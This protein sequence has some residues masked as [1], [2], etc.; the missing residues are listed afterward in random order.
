MD[1]LG[2]ISWLVCEVLRVLI[3]PGMEAQVCEWEEQTSPSP[4]V[5]L[6]PHQ[7]GLLPKHDP[8][9][10]FPNVHWDTISTPPTTYALGQGQGGFLINLPLLLGNKLGLGCEGREEG[11][12]FHRTKTQSATPGEPGAVGTGKAPRLHPHHAQLPVPQL[13]WHPWPE[14]EQRL[15]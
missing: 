6:P 10:T 15:L 4:C 5:P 1:E 12:L 14:R 3:K 8:K 13:Q 2:H 9:S 7:V 11:H